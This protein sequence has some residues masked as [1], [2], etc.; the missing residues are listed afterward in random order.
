MRAISKNG[1]RHPQNRTHRERVYR[2]LQFQKRS[3]L[4]ISAHDETLSVVMRVNN[5]HR[6]PFKIQS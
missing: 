3:Q 1:K 6:S 4:F 5:P 2:P